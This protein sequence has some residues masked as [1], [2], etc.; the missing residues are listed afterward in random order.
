MGQF[1]VAHAFDNHTYTD[2]QV[3]E[4]WYDTT[5]LLKKSVDTRF[6]LVWLIAAKLKPGSLTSQ[7]AGNRHPEQQ[8]SL[9]HIFS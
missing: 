7:S 3:R 5:K 6:P 2:V 8:G 9:G 4:W 1:V